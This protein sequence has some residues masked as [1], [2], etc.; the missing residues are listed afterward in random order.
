[1]MN[2]QLL[3][4]DARLPTRGTEES[5][6]LDLYAVDDGE[7]PPGELRVID[8]GIASSFSKYMVGLIRDR[9]SLASRGFVTAGGV[10]DSDYRGEWK[11]VL[12]NTTQDIS[13]RYERGDRIAQVIFMSCFLDEP[14]EVA[15]VGPNSVTRFGG[16][17]STGR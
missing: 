16:F 15:T 2:F 1:M 11:V 3:H 7:I 9:S 17:G 5:A 4:P 6:G 10:I 14:R 13:Y 8:L 12:R